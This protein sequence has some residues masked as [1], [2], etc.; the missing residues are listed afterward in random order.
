MSRAASVMAWITGALVGALGIV[1]GM[2]RGRRYEIEVREL[3]FKLVMAEAES[4]R[5]SANADALAD[6]LA[7]V[8]R[9]FEAAVAMWRSACYATGDTIEGEANAIVAADAANRVR[10]MAHLWLPRIVG[11][12]K[13]PATDGGKPAVAVQ[14]EA[15][16]DAASDTDPGR[17]GGGE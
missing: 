6:E 13:A 12:V 17:R 16:S 3:R 2:L 1:V 8:T 14:A 9:R 4:A 10:H 5:M 11:V 15:V 7:D